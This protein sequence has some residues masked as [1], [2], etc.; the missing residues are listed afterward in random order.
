[1]KQILTPGRPSVIW[2]YWGV[3]RA[4][5]LSLRLV[6]LHRKGTGFSLYNKS[7]K[8][9]YS[10]LGVFANVGRFFPTWTVWE[11]WRRW[12]K[13]RLDPD[14]ASLQRRGLR[15]IAAPF[16]S[17]LPHLRHLMTLVPTV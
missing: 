6:F 3:R 2:G 13:G 7:Q 8:H 5:P 17:Q 14:P 16:P 9:A 12:G 15:Q 11:G 1:M 4:T 10:D